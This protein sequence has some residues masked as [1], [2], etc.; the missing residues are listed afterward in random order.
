MFEFI[1]FVCQDGE[2]PLHIACADGAVGVVSELLAAG[3][4]IEARDWVSELGS[5]CL[6][7][8]SQ[9]LTV[10]S[11]WMDSPPS[12]LLWR[13]CEVGDSALVCWGFN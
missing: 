1:S 10:S 6:Y 13:S 7:T 4:Q 12:C 3:A 8:V 11:G 5:E 9:R 2:T